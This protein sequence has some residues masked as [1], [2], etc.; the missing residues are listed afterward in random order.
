MYNHDVEYF[1][2]QMSFFA[3]KYINKVHDLVKFFLYRHMTVGNP[4][5]ISQNKIVVFAQYLA[6]VDKV[7]LQIQLVFSDSLRE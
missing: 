1:N 5:S 3:R 6:N 7:R 2:H 4:Q